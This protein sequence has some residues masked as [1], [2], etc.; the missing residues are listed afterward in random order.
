MQIL[1]SNLSFH[2]PHQ[3]RLACHQQTGMCSMCECTTSHLMLQERLS[4][5]YGR[6]RRTDVRELSST[7][8]TILVPPLPSH[9]QDRRVQ[10]RT[11]AHVANLI[12]GSLLLSSSVF[13]A[14][15]FRCVITSFVPT[16]LILQAESLKRL[17][18]W[19]Q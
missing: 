15:D 7:C 6:L 17:S 13:Q 4:K 3:C 5:L 10:I 1:S 19:R 2:N 16:Y 9:A 12:S 11:A 8:A 14:V 18:Q